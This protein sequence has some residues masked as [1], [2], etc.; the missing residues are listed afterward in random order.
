M[1]LKKQDSQKQSA[2]TGLYRW[3][4]NLPDLDPFDILYGG[5]RW[6]V[7]GYS[8]KIHKQKMISKEFTDIHKSEP[9]FHHND[10]ACPW[11]SVL[12]KAMQ[13]LPNIDPRSTA[14]AW[15]EQ[16]GPGSHTVR[17]E[18]CWQKPVT[19]LQPAFDLFKVIDRHQK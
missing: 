6:Y 11:K 4:N 2:E 3:A 10:G 14:E 18:P 17:F 7:V 5:W 8:E 9:N 1:L 13:Q 12:E 16:E 19:T 15:L